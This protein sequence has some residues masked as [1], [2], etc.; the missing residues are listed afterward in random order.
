MARS[1]IENAA[2]VNIRDKFGCTPLMRAGENGH[3]ELAQ[4]LINNGADTEIVDNYG[5]KAVGWAR[6][7]GKFK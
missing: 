7:R 4:L 6:S 5:D 3:K 2:N 1:L